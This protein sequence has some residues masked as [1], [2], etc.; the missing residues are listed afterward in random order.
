MK[1]SKE[2]CENCGGGEPFETCRECRRLLC[3]CCFGRTLLDDACRACRDRAD[4]ANRG[5]SSWIDLYRQL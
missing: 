3:I 4:E 5:S 1:R 2:R